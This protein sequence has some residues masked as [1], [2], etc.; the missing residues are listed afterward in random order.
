MN[1]NELAEEL[2]VSSYYILHH[3]KEIYNRN[4]KKGIKLV[5]SGKGSSANYGVIEKGESFA[6]F[7]TKGGKAGV[8]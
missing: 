8:R 1:I 6:R 7:N 3:W 2:G 5:K 4:N